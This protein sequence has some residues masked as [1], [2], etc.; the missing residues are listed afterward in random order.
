MGVERTT[1]AMTAA[2]VVR[3]RQLILRGLPD[4][5]ATKLPS[6]PLLSSGYNTVSKS[7]VLLFMLTFGVT[8]YS[9]QWVRGTFTSRIR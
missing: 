4:P 9:A 5:Y 3:R 6:S 8:L 7:H 1:F 2:C